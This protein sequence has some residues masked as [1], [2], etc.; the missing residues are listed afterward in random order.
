MK[1]MGLRMRKRTALLTGAALACIADALA[2]LMDTMKLPGGFGIGFAV[3]VAS[4]CALVY[5]STGPLRY[6]LLASGMTGAEVVVWEIAGSA[7]SD[8]DVF[9]MDVLLLLSAW[10]WIAA[11]V[12]CLSVALVIQAYRSVSSRAHSGKSRGENRDGHNCC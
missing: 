4:G 3:V 12:V 1:T 8:Q 7:G 11:A 5:A 6:G 9:G 10:V 2:F